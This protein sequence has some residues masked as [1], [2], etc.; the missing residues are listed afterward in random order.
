MLLGSL[1]LLNCMLIPVTL[2]SNYLNVM[3]RMPFPQGSVMLRPILAC[4][5]AG[6]HYN[7]ILAHMTSHD[8]DDAGRHPNS[9]QR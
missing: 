4:I 7:H 9:D 8:K 6:G 3:P 1:G 5:T 2:I